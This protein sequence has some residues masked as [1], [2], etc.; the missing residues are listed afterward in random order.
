MKFEW[1]KKK[2][3]QNFNKHKVTFEEAETVFD[4]KNAITLYDELHSADEDRYIIIGVSEGFERKLTVC[5]CYRGEF[6]EITR[7]ISARRANKHE[8]KI[9]EEGL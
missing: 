5:H 1:D 9:Y 6:D 4:D 3:E 7:I 2:N 8:T